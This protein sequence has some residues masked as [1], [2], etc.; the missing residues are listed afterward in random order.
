MDNWMIGARLVVLAYCILHYLQGD[1]ERVPLVLLMLLAYTSF[2]VLFYIFKN[3]IVSR[4]SRI[5]SIAI[6]VAASIVTDL[7][8]LLLIS[9][10]ILELLS[11][12]TDNWKTS[13]FFIAVPSVLAGK[14][15]LPE[16]IAFSLLVLLIYSLAANH[17]RSFSELK[18]INERLRDRN[19]ELIGRLD[20]GSEYEA[21]M[22]YLSQIEERNSLAQK[23]HDKV[24]H[25]LAG[26][27]IQLEAAGLI[28]EKDRDKAG[29]IVRNVTE[30]LKDGMDSIR[31]TLHTIKPA[32]EQLGINRLKL[33]LEEFT[34]NHAI[35]TFLSYTGSLDVISHLQWKIIIDNIKESLTNA[36]KYSSAT[37]INV[38]LEVMNR[39]IKAEVID[40]GKGAFSI[41]KGMGLSGMEERTENAGGKLILD[42]SGGFSVIT[43]L[44]AE[45]VNIVNVKPEE[46]ISDES[47]EDLNAY[48][49]TNRG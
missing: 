36:L 7:P 14:D 18:K 5:V 21:Q 20:A 48:Q 9:V 33:I 32:P 31:I 24:G 16:Y 28:L 15:W 17:F 30:N 1:M 45:Q 43:L 42:G 13:L 40:N 34:M 10:D 47:E 29:E 2:T 46:Q 23:I 22:R 19:E 3:P 6:L 25:T 12:F 49:S 41:K 35:K 44:P 37:R 8:Y 11:D 39:L 38:R 4:S 27:I 26:S